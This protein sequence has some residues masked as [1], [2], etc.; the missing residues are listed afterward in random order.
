LKKYLKYT[1]GFFAAVLLIYF[2]IDIQNLEDKKEASEPPGFDLIEYSAKFWNDS[3]PL[4]IA[5][6][7]ELISIMQM[8]NENPEKAFKRFGNKLG[9]SKTYYF[10]AKDKGLIKKINSEY[11]EL[12]L[13]NHQTVKIATDFIFG[14]A[15]RDGSGKVNIN[16]FLNMTDFN[17]VSI[18]INKMVKEKVVPY[19][20]KS[21][22]IGKT[23][24]FAGAM[25][26]HKEN[27][28]LSKVL[29]IPVSVKISDGQTE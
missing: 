16:D 3:L 9:I 6:A 26:L 28:E 8:L 25:D 21:A 29:L 24:E 10:L 4:C 19:L 27:I 23:L 12:V 17:N 7:P 5:S 1:I 18:T 14:N 11:I 2:S 20:Q 13:E 22:E 15:V